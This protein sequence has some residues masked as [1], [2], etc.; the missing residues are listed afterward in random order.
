MNSTLIWSGDAP[1]VSQVVTITPGDVVAGRAYALRINGKDVTA[2]GATAD[3]LVDAFVDAIEESEIPEFAEI[4]PTNGGGVLVLTSKDPGT[5]FKV[6]ALV[7]GFVQG[8]AIVVT[9]ANEPTGGDWHFDAGIYGDDD[10]A[11]DAS[12][13]AAQTVMDGL[14]GAG[15][16]V[17]TK[18][19]SGTA[20]IYTIEF[21]AGMAGQAVPAV[22]VSYAGLT[23]GNAQ[24]VVTVEQTAIV[25]TSEVQTVTF[26]GMS[27]GSGTFLAE[28]DG[29]QTGAITWPPT[30]G[31]LQ[32]ALRGLS[33]VN[34]ANLNVSGSTG[35]PYT[36]T[37]AGAFA[38]KALPLIRIDAR[39]LTGTIGA[40][41]ATTTPGVAG[42]NTIQYLEQLSGGGADEVFT[43]KRSGTVSGGTFKWTYDSGGSQVL[44][45]DVQWD[46]RL[47]QMIAAL[48]AAVATREGSGYSG[49]YFAAAVAG[50]EN[51]TMAD[52]GGTLRIACIGSSGGRDLTFGSGLIR[53]I[54]ISSSLTGGGTYAAPSTGGTNG[55]WTGGTLA[56]TGSMTLQIGAGGT[57]SAPIT[58]A[59]GTDGLPSAA[60]IADATA[61]LEALP[62]VGAGNVRLTAWAYFPLSGGSARGLFKAEFI[63]SLTG[64]AVAPIVGLPSTPPTT[65]DSWSPRAYM[66]QRGIAGTSE[67]QTLTVTGSPSHGGLTVS[68]KG[69][70]SAEI[71]YNSSAANA[72]GIVEAISTV[73]PGKFTTG[74]GALPGTPLTFTGAGGFVY[75]DLDEFV[76]NDSAL[77][78][79][80]VETT[81]G[82]TGRNEIQRLSLKGQDIWAGTVTCTTEGH[83]VSALAYNSTLALIVAGLETSAGLTAGDLSLSTG[84]PWPETDVLIEFAG[85]KA[86]TDA[87]LITATDALKNGT[88]TAVSYDPL[89][90]RTTVKATGP[91]HFNSPGN[92][93]NPAAP[94]TFKAPE[95]GDT[96]Y[97]TE[98]TIDMLYGGVLIVTFTADTT[99]EYLIPDKDHDLAEGQIVEVWSSGSLPSGLSSNT[100]YYVRNI[101]SSTG[102]FQLST[103]ATGAVV[104]L[105][106]A[107]SPTHWVGVRVKKFETWSTWTGAAGLTWWNSAGYKEYRPL[108]IEIGLLPTG[109]G[110]TTLVTIGKGEGNG[111]NLFSIY[112][113]I[114]PVIVECL[115]SAGGTE[116]TRPAV[117]WRGDNATAALKVFGGDFGVALRPTESASFNTLEIR[118]GAVRLGTVSFGSLDKT[119][120]TFDTVDSATL[121]GVMKIRG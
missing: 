13:A 84:G 82:V 109:Q 50:T 80:V 16:T 57:P 95:R 35:G 58:L 45:D 41:I 1:A 112:T 68:Y 31:T 10:I 92:W 94:T 97:A 59:L 85:S 62:E 70:E 27:S 14:F 36:V 121:S 56:T 28:F 26:Y 89:I 86:E 22:T 52:G 99:N 51:Y 77:K 6:T 32:T 107:G 34:G 46:G 11:Y 39:N 91:N 55:N 29:V 117:N 73:G 111:S 116:P 60:M 25:G 69:E 108:D 18:T 4:T 47:H 48:E 19:T 40:S 75:S 78:V 20:V 9:I 21:I 83:A 96:L 76:V 71:V 101:D 5:P 24:L 102:K 118:G 79:Q 74:G 7:G 88:A 15:N 30:S 54:G 66:L 110:G 37:G 81:P 72:D 114:D 44:S 64:A 103:A 119:G 8:A 33:S 38:H 104:N 65:G 115:N 100:S 42:Q 49:P 12:Q 23:G 105:S 113:G 106:T 98:G 67:V 120:G 43:I 3:T 2:S 61:K 87:N 93:R 90:V 53:A 63:N 17:V